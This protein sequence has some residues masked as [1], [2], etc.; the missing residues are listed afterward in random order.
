MFVCSFGAP[1]L[2]R[3]CY[4]QRKLVDQSLW[5]VLII[6]VALASTRWTRPA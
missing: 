4:A 5:C 6:A 2:L 1:H 3:S